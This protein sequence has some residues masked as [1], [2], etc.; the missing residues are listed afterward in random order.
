MLRLLVLL[1]SLA[2]VYCSTQSIH[3]PALKG[4]VYI[5]TND[6]TPPVLRKT[7]NEHL[8][9]T[10]LLK[11]TAQQDGNPIAGEIF[12]KISNDYVHYSKFLTSASIKTILQLRQNLLR[13]YNDPTN[14]SQASSRFDKFVSDFRTDTTEFDAF[15]FTSI[16]F[17]AQP[18]IGAH[19]Y[20]GPQLAKLR[21]SIIQSMPSSATAEQKTDFIAFLDELISSFPNG[22]NLGAYLTYI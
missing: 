16:D 7:F 12:D 6:S 2:I 4:T 1:C 17:L 3:V 8:T 20:L 13:F 19:D 9:G 18:L 10:M 22:D 15:A 11:A 21:T 5:T 14:Y